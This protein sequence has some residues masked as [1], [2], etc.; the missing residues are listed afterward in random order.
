MKDVAILAGVSRSAVSRCFTDGASVSLKMREK[1][2][3]AAKELGYQPNA[4]ASSLTT[5][6]T[7]LIGLISNNFRNPMF[8][9][10]FDLFT[11]GLQLKGLRPLLLNLS[12]EDEP[13]HAVAMLKQYSVDGVI[14][15][16]STLSPCFAKAF[17]AAGIPIV[18]AF[19]G[20]LNHGD[21]PF[22]SVDNVESGRLAARVL[23]ECGYKD[24]GF[25]GGPE[26]ASSTQDRLLGFKDV[27]EHEPLVKFRYSFA[28]DYSFQSGRLSMQGE[29]NG[30]QAEAYFCGDDVLAIG[31]ASAVQDRG[32]NIPNDIGLLGLNDMEM[33]GWNNI[34]L[35]TLAQPIDD[36]VNE[37]LAL[38]EQLVLGQAP[39]EIKKVFKCHLVARGTLK[40]Q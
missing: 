3:L 13:D 9:Q 32:L 10:V 15:A 39:Q 1:V 11:R 19:G 35:T 30:K 38:M 26:K 34:N 25:L 21:V 37:S 36:I 16:S 12:E 40:N 23:L 28:Q 29:L 24:I 33:A 18:H 4:L 17:S 14:V 8:L 31:A 6:R 20:H 22:V 5:G 7:K 27:L 2:E